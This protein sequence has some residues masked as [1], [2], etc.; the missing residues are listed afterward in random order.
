[1]SAGTVPGMLL[2]MPSNPGG[3]WADIRSVMIAPPVAALRNV[4][5]V[6]EALHQLCPGPRYAGRAPAELAWLAGVSVARYRR[7]HQVKGVR[8]ARAVGGRVGEQVDDAEHLD[9]RAGPAV[10]DDERQRVLVG[11]TDVDEVDVE[12]VY[13]GHEVRQCTEPRLEPAPVIILRPVAREF[14]GHVQLEA[15]RVVGDEFPVGPAGGVDPR[16]QCPQFRFGGDRDLEWPDRC[17]A[18]QLAGPLRPTGTDGRAGLG[19]RAPGHTELGGAHGQGR[20]A[21]R[22]EEAAPAVADLSGPVT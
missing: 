14:L 11:R 21:C 17:A 4:V 13:L 19:R 10:R 16:A 12:S 9:D 20:R 5:R 3:A 7:D 15:L 18:R 2:C 6:A 22:A 8:C 1:M